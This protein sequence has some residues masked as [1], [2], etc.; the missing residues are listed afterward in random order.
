MKHIVLSDHTA[1]RLKQKEAERQRQYEEACKAYEENCKQIDI[2]YQ[3]ALKTYEDNLS[4]RLHNINLLKLQRKEAW[5]QRKWWQAIKYTFKVIIATI[6][7][8]PNMPQKPTLPPAPIKESPDEDDNIWQS[9]NMGEQKVVS[10]LQERLDDNY[11]LFSGYKNRKGEIDKILVGPEGIF[12]IEI[13]NINGHIN[14]DGDQ[15]WKDKY[16]KYGNLVEKHQSIED[17]TGRSPSMQLNEPSDMLQNFL[18]KR[19][20]P[21]CQICR[22]VVF[23]H[24]S[25]RI[26]NIN[27]LTV[28]EVVILEDWNLNETFRK[29]TLKLSPS[30]I[31]KVAKKIEEDHNYMNNKTKYNHSKKI[32][33]NLSA[34]KKTDINFLGEGHG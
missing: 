25:S 17:K 23:T 6:S 18:A 1:D 2:A 34:E 16:D 27:N 26:Q 3:E 13:K 4:N 30:E 11:I 29:S 14:C 31:S 33:K 8:K 7:G 24:E 28:N 21:S 12:A 20:L 9:G 32:N 19:I 15:W 5:E 22:I 10:Y